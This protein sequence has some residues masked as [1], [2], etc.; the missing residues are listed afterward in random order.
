[1][2]KYFLHSPY[3]SAKNTKEKEA[4]AAL[5]MLADNLVSEIILDKLVKELRSDI[6]KLNE[7]HKRS[8]TL[9]VRMSGSITDGHRVL[10]IDNGTGSS[11]ASIQVY[12]V[13]NERY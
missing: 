4:A 12:R 5:R 2:E 9:S 8:R 10:Y 1:M 7:E 3:S 11:V 13:A 6:D